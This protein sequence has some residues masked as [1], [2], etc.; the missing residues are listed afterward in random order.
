MH[1][2][3]VDICVGTEQET[4]TFVVFWGGN[5][6]HLSTNEITLIQVICSATIDQMEKPPF[7]YNTLLETT[8]N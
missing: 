7:Y 2:I 1:L 6:G 5:Q 3:V 4:T 8:I